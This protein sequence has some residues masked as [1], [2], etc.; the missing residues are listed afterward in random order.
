MYYY[1]PKYMYVRTV[2]FAF[3]TIRTV[4]VIYNIFSFGVYIMLSDGVYN[5][6]VYILYHNTF[7]QLNYQCVEM[8]LI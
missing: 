1:R 8:Y 7:V 2:V 5:T 4:Y 3:V 6:M